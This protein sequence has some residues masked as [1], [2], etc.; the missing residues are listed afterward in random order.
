MKRYLLTGLSTS[1]LCAVIAAERTKVKPVKNQPKIKQR[2][3]EKKCY[4]K[5][6]K[7]AQNSQDK[8]I[9]KWDGFLMA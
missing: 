9:S 5:G 3:N 1:I 4:E 2:C 8:P 6:K 7:L